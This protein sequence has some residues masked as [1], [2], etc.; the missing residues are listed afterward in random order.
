MY[1]FAQVETIGD[2]YM[3]VSGIPKRNGDRH[4]AE[5]ANMALSIREAVENFRIRHMPERP[6]QVRIG[7]HTG[8]CAAGV[9]GLTMPRYCLF[10]DTVNMASRMES[11]G[12][13]MKIQLS[14]DCNSAL[15]AVGGYVTSLR[16]PIPIKV[17]IF[18][19]YC[20]LGIEKNIFSCGCIQPFMNHDI[21]FSNLKEENLR[22]PNRSQSLPTGLA[23]FSGKRSGEHLL[24]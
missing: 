9:V 11:N 21:T 10:G 14:P 15:T 2:S 23:T 7:L 18:R 6:M 1:H 4:V 17:S 13:A 5:I 8:P 22:S 20:S 16:G 19:Y 24:A 3:C 12:L